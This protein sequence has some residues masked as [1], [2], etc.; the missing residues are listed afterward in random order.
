VVVNSAQSLKQFHNNEKKASS[1]LKILARIIEICSNSDLAR[2]ISING[3]NQNGIKPRD[4]R[5]NDSVRVRLQA[6]FE[7][8]AFDGYSFEVKRGEEGSGKAISNEYAGKL[9][10]AFDLNE[11]WSC[12]QT[13][14]VFDEKYAHIFARPEVSA[15][16]IIFLA[17]IMSLIEKYLPD[18]KNASFAIMA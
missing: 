18:V 14:K 9:L 11:L 12:H 3:N 13:Y 6:E 8:L 2:E 5:S 10:L 7:K 1:D 15:R 17:E 4:F 16:R